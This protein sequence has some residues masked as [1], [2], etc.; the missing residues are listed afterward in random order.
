MGVLLALRKGKHEKVAEFLTDDDPR[1]VA[2]A[3]R[4]IYD[5][6][7]EAAQPALAKL[8]EKAGQPDAVAYRALAANYVLGTAEC[9][10]RVAKFAGRQGEPDHTRAFA[11]KLLGDWQKPPR[12]DP[13]TGLTLDLQ[14]RDAKIPAHAIKAA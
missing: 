8:A 10:A 12:R 5:V 7:I 4:A 11:L 13:I 3:A 2:E 14:P 1:I 9:A 6:R